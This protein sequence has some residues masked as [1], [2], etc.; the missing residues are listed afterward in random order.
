MTL[1][2]LIDELH[3]LRHEHGGTIDVL[4]WPRRHGRYERELNR[5]GETRADEPV[6]HVRGHPGGAVRQSAPAKV[7]M[8]E[9]C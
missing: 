7:V 3:Q 9:T 8:I 6:A 4:T 5:R 2:Q 1:D